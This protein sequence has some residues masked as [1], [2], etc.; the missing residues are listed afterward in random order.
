MN[1]KL[2]IVIAD[3]HQIVIDGIKL[4]LADHKDIEVVGEALNGKELLS[5]LGKKY[6]D[7][8]IVDISMP[9][10]NGMEATQHIS[11]VYPHVKVIIL[12]MHNEKNYILKIIE[13]GAK[14]F[15]L[16]NKS[17]EEL[18]KAIYNVAN[19]QTHFGDDILSVLLNDK[20]KKQSS[21]IKLT[22]KEK[23]VLRLLT[24]EF[25]TDEI[26]KKLFIEPTTV[27]THRKHL[28]KKIGSKNIVGL[29]KYAIEND[30]T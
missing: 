17:K 9:I 10:M 20:T 18:V 13:A 4:I 5:I 19:N 27:T 6:V 26:A 21:P 11:E 25:T 12:T 22:K 14:G 29:I 16:K 30:Y 7:I 23:E 2:K 28:S 15:I 24:Q 1:K 3:D 8:A